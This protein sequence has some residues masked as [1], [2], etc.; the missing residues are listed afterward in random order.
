MEGGQDPC[1]S[2]LTWRVALTIKDTGGPVWEPF[3]DLLDRTPDQY[4]LVYEL[5]SGSSKAFGNLARRAYGA[6]G[7][8]LFEGPVLFEVQALLLNDILR[9]MHIRQHNPKVSEQLAL[10]VYRA[11]ESDLSPRLLANTELAPL[12]SKR[13]REYW[14]MDEAAEEEME[15]ESSRARRLT[16]HLDASS[17]DPYY[18]HL[19]HPINIGGGV[20]GFKRLM[21]VAQH[22]RR[23][24]ATLGSALGP[25]LRKTQDLGSIELAELSRLMQDGLREARKSARSR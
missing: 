8:D 25:V 16:L 11:I 5:L 7:R 18:V 1:S 19:D 20:K 17:A 10:F 23:T 15:A 13:A 6:L 12:V 4:K 21:F 3:E 22:Y 9:M 14:D 2:P 24:R